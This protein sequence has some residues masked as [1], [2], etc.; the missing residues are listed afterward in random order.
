MQVLKQQYM[1]YR[2]SVLNDNA[3]PFARKANNKNFAGPSPF[4]K[5]QAAPIMQNSTQPT[6]LLGRSTSFLLP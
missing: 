1:S 2:R 6:S 5:R 4:P 3:D